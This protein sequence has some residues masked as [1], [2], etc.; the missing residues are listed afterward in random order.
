MKSILE[1]NFAGTYFWNG[2]FFISR[3]IL[4]LS[5]NDF[6]TKISFCENT[7]FFVIDIFLTT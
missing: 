4:Y 2:V 6:H 3:L 5:E 1:F 7:F